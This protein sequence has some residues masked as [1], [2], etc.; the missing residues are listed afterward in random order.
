MD[1]V[2][3]ITPATIAYLRTEK[4]RRTHGKASLRVAIVDGPNE[5]EERF[6]ME[7]PSGVHT[8]LVVA[9]DAARLNAHW[10]VFAADPRNR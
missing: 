7:G 5:P 6:V 1:R 8:L 10:R 4:A 2:A 9:T 3:D